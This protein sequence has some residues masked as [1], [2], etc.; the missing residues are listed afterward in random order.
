MAFGVVMFN[1]NV[2]LYENMK[3]STTHACSSLALV[4][5]F[6]EGTNTLI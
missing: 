1:T 6:H 3:S 2:Y 4:K 5:I